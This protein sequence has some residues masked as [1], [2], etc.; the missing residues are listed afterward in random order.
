MKHPMRKA[1][2][3]DDIVAPVIQDQVSA[4]TLPKLV[5]LELEIFSNSIERNTLREQNFF[6]DNHFARV[7]KSFHAKRKQFQQTCKLKALFKEKCEVIEAEYHEIEW[8]NQTADFDDSKDSV[9]LHKECDEEADRLV[10]E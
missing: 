5:I 7:F 6:C 1:R 3:A 2:Q 9:L 10:H 8:V 4:I